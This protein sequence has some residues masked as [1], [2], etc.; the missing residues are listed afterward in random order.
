MCVCVC[1]CA[2]FSFSNYQLPTVLPCFMASSSF[3][4]LHGNT[5]NVCVCMSVCGRL[6][7]RHCGDATMQAI[8]VTETEL[9]SYTWP[10]LGIM[11][12]KKFHYYYSFFRFSIHLRRMRLLSC[13]CS[14]HF[15]MRRRWW[16]WWADHT[17][18]EWTYVVGRAFA[19]LLTHHSTPI[20]MKQSYAMA[21]VALESRNYSN[22]GKLHSDGGGRIN[23]QIECQSNNNKIVHFV[24]TN[25]KKVSHSEKLERPSPSPAPITTPSLDS[26]NSRQRAQWKTNCNDFN[27]R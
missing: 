15:A 11:W 13:A 19:R 12:L 27:L 17:D 18:G 24:C 23:F 7:K 16:R 21:M 3:S 8:S 1:V 9:V 5:T 2:L 22:F 26:L 20:E 4:L 10:K 14:R 25:G 6:V